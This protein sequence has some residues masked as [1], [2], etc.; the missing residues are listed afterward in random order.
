M[1]QPE[2]P[3]G[4]SDAGHRIHDVVIVGAGHNGLVAAA[5][6]ARAGVSTTVLERSDQVG[7]C[8]LT[9]DIAPGF[10]C[11]TLAHRAAIDPDIARALDLG[12]CGLEIVEGAARACAPTR[13]GRALTLWSA[14]A[15]AAHEIAA[16]SARDAERY[17]RFLATIASIS[18]VLQTL[19]S[20]PAPDL[21]GLNAGD[22]VRG[23]KTLRRF[24]ALPTA[25]AYRV[26][27]WLPMSA[28]DLVHEWFDSDP[29]GV[30]VAADGLLGSFVGPRSAGSGASLLLLAARQGQPIAPGWSARGGIGAVGRALAEATRRAGAEIRTG[31]DVKQITVRPDGAAGVVLSTGEE[32]TA[33][34][35]VS[36]ADPRRTL[37]GLVAPAHLSPAIRSHLQGIRMRGVLSK[38]NYAVSRLPAV[39]ALARLDS[40]RQAAALSGCLRLCPDIDSA[41]RA[42]DAAKYGRYSDEPWIELAI[43]SLADPGLAPRRQHVISV[44]VQFTPFSLRGST[45]DEEREPLGD[46]VTRIIEQ[47]APGFERSIV[48]RQV[49]TPLD[50]ERTFGLTGGHIFH[51]EL[52]LDQL[53]LARPLLGWAQHRTPIRNLYLCGSGTHPGTGLDGRSGALAAKA[54]LRDLRQR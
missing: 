5:F 4:R 54:I 32:I 52:A 10:R 14:A 7:G 50:L 13:D 33:R 51:G 47:Y 8:A 37:L 39:T 2:T 30:L 38:V 20:S 41:E 25:D 3:V 31:A 27:R 35:V 42:F 1:T 26:L 40:S 24:R 21:D 44:Y 19:M 53:L 43:P 9:S 29:L 12:R 15:D 36:N 16:F 45:W 46:L 17:P 28:A 34:R 18:G 11:S 22:L 6:L 23:L 48:A 49:I